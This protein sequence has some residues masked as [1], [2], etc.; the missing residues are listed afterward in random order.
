[1]VFPSVLNT[2]AFSSFDWF[3]CRS[4]IYF[5]YEGGSDVYSWDVSTDL[6]P[7]NCHLIHRGDS[8]LLATQA[9]LDPLRAKVR[10]LQSNV[11]DFLR[12][13]VGVG[14]IHVLSSS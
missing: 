1:M 9:V 3:S 10:L 2:M 7:E 11:L 4:T 12:K 8:A 5:R 13:A 6:E 14:A